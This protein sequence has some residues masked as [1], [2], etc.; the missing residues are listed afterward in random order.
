MFQAADINALFGFRIECIERLG[1][2]NGL[3]AW[4]RLNSLFNWLPLAACIEDK[5]LCMHGGERYPC[6]GCTIP[7]KPEP[8][9]LKAVIAAFAWA[10][11]THITRVTEPGVILNNS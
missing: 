1:E 5:V 6:P 9:H 8:L 4:T 10:A 7:C 11:L 2:R 3:W